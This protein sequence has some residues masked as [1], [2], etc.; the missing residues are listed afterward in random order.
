MKRLLVALVVPL[1][2]VT[3]CGSDDASKRPESFSA[4]GTITINKALKLAAGV[5]TGDGGYDDIR[6]GT[7]VVIRDSGG[8]QIALGALDSG[9]I[10]L[11][12]YGAVIRC[13]FGFDVPGVPVEGEIYSV[14][15]AHRGEISF[16]R[17]DAASIALSLG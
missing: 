3:G 1:I 16:Q 4:H 6:A 13:S 14:E 12:G 2:L 9:R 8:K 7:Q 15:V 5:C 11:E 10:E 17:A